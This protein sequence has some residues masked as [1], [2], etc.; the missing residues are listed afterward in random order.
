MKLQCGWS[1]RCGGRK[2]YRGGGKGI[3]NNRLCDNLTIEVDDEL[4]TITITNI[5][6]TL[7]EEVAVVGDNSYRVNSGMIEIILDMVMIAE[8]IS[9]G[10]VVKDFHLKN[11]A[12]RIVENRCSSVCSMI[13]VFFF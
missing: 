7:E 2:R 3:Y 9:A 1:D 10:A 5:V 4:V 8:Q 13:M 11:Q 6:I 12:M